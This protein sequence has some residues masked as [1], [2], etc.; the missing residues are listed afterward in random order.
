MISLTEFGGKSKFGCLSEAGFR[1]AK[2][3]VS[4]M[5]TWLMKNWPRMYSRNQVLE[6]LH[7]HHQ[8]TIVL[9]RVTVGIVELCQHRMKMDVAALEKFHAYQ[10]HLCSRNLSLIVMCLIL[11]RGTWTMYL[12]WIILGTMRILD[13]LLIGNMFYGNLAA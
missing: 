6:H 2:K 12:L 9:S 1:A 8:K 13:M 5:L 11:P 7:H 4:S 10:Q 3:A